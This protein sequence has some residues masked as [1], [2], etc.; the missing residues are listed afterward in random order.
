[1][2]YE[3]IYFVR[4]QRPSKK[5]KASNHFQNQHSNNENAKKN[6][7]KTIYIRRNNDE[8]TKIFENKVV[9]SS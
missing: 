7:Q 2:L 4:K 5:K 9:I 6:V 8:K 1:M 3:S